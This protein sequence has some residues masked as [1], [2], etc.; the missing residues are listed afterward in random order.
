MP[1]LPVHSFIA[2][3]LWVY[4]SGGFPEE[5]VEELSARKDLSAAI[6]DLVAAGAPVHGECAGLLWLTRTLDA[7]PMLGIIET[8]AAM[9]RRL[10][11]GY[12]EAV[13]LQD[14]VLYRAGERITG[15]EFHHTALTSEK[16]EGFAP[17]WGWRRWD[18]SPATEG[19]TNA[20]IH[21]SYLHVHPASV[22]QAVRRFVDAAR[23]FAR[24]RSD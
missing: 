9:G 5:H 4:Y 18:G 8:H 14:S 13:V 16:A 22:P 15:H 6:A 10:T 11:L 20:T 23:E 17:A 7:H 21:A 1:F 24:H 2:T 12:R 19:F 3:V